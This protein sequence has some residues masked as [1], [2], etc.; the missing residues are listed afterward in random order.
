MHSIGTFYFEFGIW[1]FSWASD[2]QRSV[3]PWCWAAAAAPSPSCGQR[4]SSQHLHSYHSVSIQPLCLSLSVLKSVSYMNHSTRGYTVRFVSDDLLNWTSC[5]SL[6]WAWLSYDIQQ[7][8]CIQCI[9]SLPWVYW[10]VTLSYNEEDLYT[11]AFN[12]LQS[13]PTFSIRL[14]LGS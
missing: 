4:V 13:D 8:R 2:L 1:I 3:L 14:Y 11:L 7:V 6:R 5:T 9:F 10:F 12:C